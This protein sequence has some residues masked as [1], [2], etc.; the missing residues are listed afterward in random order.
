[1]RDDRVGLEV[2]RALLARLP[3]G[4]AV[5]EEACV[6]GMELLH[7]LE[8][9]QRVVIVDAFK[10]GQ[11]EPG[12]V[13]ELP[14]EELEQNYTP[15]SPHTAGLLTCLEFG[16]ACGLSMP[17]EVRVFVIGVNDPYTFSESCTP[18]VA[19]AI[20]RIVEFILEQA[21]RPDHRS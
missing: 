3:E 9:W 13:T 16:R 4:T 10:P 20:P 21:F 14:L 1:L 6:G 17:E 15:I 12:E 11:L 2:A 5:L 8:G 18:E 19:E 7:I